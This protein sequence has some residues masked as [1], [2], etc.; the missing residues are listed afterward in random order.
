MSDVF[1]PVMVMVFE[2]HSYLFIDYT[3][4]FD[5]QSNVYNTDLCC[6]LQC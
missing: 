3:K 1:I 2:E 4:G 5:V 6:I